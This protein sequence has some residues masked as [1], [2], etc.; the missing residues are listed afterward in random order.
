M[1]FG[2]ELPYHLPTNKVE[3][4][5]L[6]L[7]TPLSYEAQKKFLISTKARIPQQHIF[8]IVVQ[9]ATD[10]QNQQDT[11]SETNVE[12]PT[13]ADATT[14]KAHYCYPEEDWEAFWQ[15]SLSNLPTTPYQVAIT[16]KRPG[17]IANTPDHLKFLEKLGE[18]KIRSL[19]WFVE[20]SCP[21]IS[22]PRLGDWILNL[23]D[24]WVGEDTYKNFPLSPEEEKLKKLLENWWKIWNFE[25]EIEKEKVWGPIF[26]YEEKYTKKGEDPNPNF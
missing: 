15:K 17:W 12:L 1:K 18:R 24:K 22:L 16:L 11:S 9:R 6:N 10:D 25:A 23:E 2:K 19:K 21:R 13:S 8:K 14:R 3:V 5:K 7:R 20:K 26:I 4:P